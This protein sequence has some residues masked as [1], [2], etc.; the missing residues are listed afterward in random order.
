MSIKK[1]T[2]VLTGIRLTDQDLEDN[3][4]DL[5][6]DELQ[7]Y[8][9]QHENVE[10]AFLFGEGSDY[11]YFGKI[12]VCSEPYSNDISKILIFP[13]HNNIA[14]LL[15]ATKL[16]STQKFYELDIQNWYFD[17]WS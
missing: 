14:S 1:S 4:I 6:S 12:V 3:N 10:L 15:N 8:R 16:F 11:Y 13:D 2:Y 5:W 7:P 17:L 9:E